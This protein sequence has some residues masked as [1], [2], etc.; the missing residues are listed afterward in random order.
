M[1]EY[2]RVAPRIDGG[3]ALS[4]DAVVNKDRGARSSPRVF[5]FLSVIYRREGKGLPVLVYDLKGQGLREGQCG[6]VG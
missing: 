4:V 3:F 6:G 2:D 5:V 1:Q